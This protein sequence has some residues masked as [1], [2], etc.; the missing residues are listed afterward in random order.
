MSPDYCVEDY[1]TENAMITTGFDDGMKAGSL[2]AL[3]EHIRGLRAIDFAAYKPG[4][5]RRC[6]QLRLAAT[7]MP[8]CASYHKYLSENPGEIDALID[9][10]TIKVSHFF[11][12]PF[13]FEALHEFVLPGIIDAFKDD[14]LRIWCAGCATGEE[15]YSLAILL[16]EFIRKEAISPKVFIIGTDI[17]RQALKDAEKALYSADSLSEVKKGRLDRYFT[18]KDGLYSLSEE[19]RSMV[20]FAY[21]DVT[22]LSTP[23]EGVFSDYHLIFCRNVLI[24]F[25][26]DACKNVLNSLSGFILKSGCLALG[27][28]EAMPSEHMLDFEEALPKTKL[29]R[30]VK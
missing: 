6:L 24:Y 15:P 21:H 16:K 28:A 11:R 2:H 4:T 9:S 29:F 13:V 8:D 3:L 20:T 10:L 5:I 27:E 30:R 19:I 17:D 23:K 12:N 1:L 14:T 25:E 22:D 18:F 26:Q 7:G